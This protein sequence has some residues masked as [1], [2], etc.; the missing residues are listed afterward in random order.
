MLLLLALATGFVIAAAP[1]TAKAAAPSRLDIGIQDPLEEVFDEHDPSGAYKALQDENISVSRFPV[2]WSFVASKQPAD[3]T[4]P[5]DPAY[6][7]GP[8][9]ARVRRIEAAGLEP[10][11]VLGDPPHWALREGS[12]GFGPRVG[13]FQAFATAIARRYSGQID[14]LPHVKYWQIWNEPNLKYY[15]DRRDN[16]NQYRLLVNAAYQRIHEAAT[17]N[18]VVAGGMAPF[19]G[20]DNVHGTPT[21]QF[22]RGLL[23]LTRADRPKPGCNKPVSFD[24]WAHHPYTSGGPNHQAYARDDV[25]LGDLPDMMHA[26]HAAERAGHVKPHRRVRFW[27]TEFSWDTKPP[28]PYGVP[29]ARHARWVAE[30]FYRMWRQGASLI[31]WF[32]LRDDP[33]AT[34]WGDSFQAGLF[35]RT[36]DLYADEKAKPLAQVIRFPFVALPSGR[37]VAIWGRAPG[38][39]AQKVAIERRKGSRW[40]RVKTLQA[41]SHGL[42]TARLRGGRGLLYRARSGDTASFSFDAVRTRDVRA[43][44]FGGPTPP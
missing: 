15:L 29:L 31:V 42:F 27:V 12:A 5:R 43:S 38:G 40:V 30:A 36:T 6:N 20:K 2:H 8:L 21:M 14:G 41:N 7:W 10:L 28:D 34:A 24:V 35:F 44:P 26:L 3:A 4:D 37:G 39:I 13:D 19:S 17:G 22:M 9:D 1:A 11:I 32:Q 25:S 23:C 33:K 18:L 16:V